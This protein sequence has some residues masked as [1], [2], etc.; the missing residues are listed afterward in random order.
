MKGSTVA[1]NLTKEP[2]TGK[3][4]GKKVFLG[5][6]GGVDSSVSA[7][8]LKEQGYD[9]TGVYMKNW[10][11]DL[12]GMKCPWAEDLADA[13]RVAV[14]LDLDFEVWDFE[15]DYKQ[16]VVDYMLAE[17]QKG[18]TPNPDIIC[19][20]LIKFKL[21]YERATQRGADFI[22][23]GHYAQTDGQNLLR[24]VDENK[25]QTYFLYRMSD[26]ATARTL[27]PVG[28][29]TK[30][31]VKK[32]AA[33]KGLDVATKKESMGVCFVGEVG[34]KDFLREYLPAR[35]GEIR[36]A[37]TEQ[38]LGYHDGAIFY[39][40]GQ[41]HGLYLGGGLP[42]YVVQK[43]LVQNIVY[44]SKD[45]N[46][47]S[48]WTRELVLEDLHWRGEG[49]NSGINHYSD[50]GGLVQD[51]QPDYLFSG[52]DLAQKPGLKVRLR[53][54]APLL[55]VKFAENKLIFAEPIR[56]PAAG[57][58]AVLYHDNICLGGGIITEA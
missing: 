8:L 14:Q 1:K 26:V 15:V 12:P 25:D 33:E 23:T 39:T 19:N 52:G 48:L 16:K 28:N 4:V 18:R 22:A 34:M 44:V 27:F 5:M 40:I 7:V 58:S 13:K 21:F 49:E 30:P 54:R 46:Y 2:S 24:A 42:Y 47:H 6:S 45:L 36:E 55:D 57:Q 20:E 53:H 43:D 3:K 50:G 32:L 51:N 17:F 31:E 41:R 56:R 11:Q 37:E 38:V 29:L 10:S 9:V 35:P